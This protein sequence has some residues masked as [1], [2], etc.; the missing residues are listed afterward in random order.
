MT[1]TPDEFTTLWRDHASVL[2]QSWAYTYDHVKDTYY[3]RD[4]KHEWHE[5]SKVRRLKQLMENND[6]QS[7]NVPSVTSEQ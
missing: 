7:N 6:A 3:D 1:A 4:D 2:L 5:G